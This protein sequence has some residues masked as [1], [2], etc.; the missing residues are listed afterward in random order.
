MQVMGV[1][2]PQLKLVPRA[3]VLHRYDRFITLLLLQQKIETEKATEN[4]L[5]MAW[6]ICRQD[7]RSQKRTNDVEKTTDASGRGTEGVYPSLH[8]QIILPNKEV[9]QCQ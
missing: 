4:L 1:I 9:F 3:L 6:N 7:K 8:R 5:L 2:F